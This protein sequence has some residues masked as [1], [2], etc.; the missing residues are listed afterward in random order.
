MYYDILNWC[1]DLVSDFVTGVFLLRGDNFFL[2]L[3][4]KLPFEETDAR[5]VRT[6]HFWFLSES[7]DFGK[8]SLWLMQKKFLESPV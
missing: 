2:N 1:I 3:K 4:E 6:A 7:D 8:E 5:S